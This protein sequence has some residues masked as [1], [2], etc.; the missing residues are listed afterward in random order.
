MED[1][2]RGNVTFLVMPSGCVL[3]LVVMEDTLR[4]FKSA[5]ELKKEM[6][7]GLNPCCNGRYSQRSYFTISTLV[8]WVLILVVM[9]DT[10]R[11]SASKRVYI[12]K[13]RSLN[14]CCNG[15]YSQS[16]MKQVEEN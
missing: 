16:R 6:V 8:S 7:D 5:R 13:I 9:E 1:T 4:V 3:I 12:N 2:L 15:R 10:L 14:P 11:D